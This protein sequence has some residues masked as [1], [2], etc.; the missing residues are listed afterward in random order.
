MSNTTKKKIFSNPRISPYKPA[1]T[2]I[3]NYIKGIE[4]DL[5]YTLY[6]FGIVGIILLALSLVMIYA[7]IKIYQVSQQELFNI[8]KFLGYS[9]YSIYSKPLAFL[10]I[11][12]VVELLTTIFIRSKA[13]TLVIIIKFIIQILFCLLYLRQSSTKQLLYSLKEE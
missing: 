6:L 7:I 5:S 10:S 13:G 12:F 3:G 11:T 8:K 2:T 9:I 4:K 1:F